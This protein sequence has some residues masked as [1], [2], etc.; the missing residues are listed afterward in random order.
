MT[1]DFIVARFWD[2]AQHWIQDIGCAH[3]AWGL[4]CDPQLPDLLRHPNRLPFCV[5]NAPVACRY[6]A[7]LAPLDWQ[8]FPERD[9]TT[10]W[11]IPTIPYAPFVA[12]Y[13]IK[14]DQQ[15]M[16][17]PGLRRY[18]VEHPVLTTILGFPPPVT[19]GMLTSDALDGCLPTHRHFARILRTMPNATLQWLLDDTVRLLQ[20]EL[21]SVTDDFGQA[22]SLDTKHILAWVKENNPKAYVKD[23]FDKDHQPAGDPDCK[24]G[25][26]RKHNQRTTGEKRTDSNEPP[27]PRRNPRSPKGIQI[28]EY[29]WGYA[30]GVIATKIF[31]WA[32]VVLAELTQTFDAADVSYFQ[33]L[34][35]DTERRLG[36]RPRFGAF[37]SAFDAWYV[38]EHF[39]HKGEPWQEAFAAVPWAKRGPKRTFDAKGLPLC[40]AGLPMPLKHAYMSRTD[41]VPH[42]KG[43]YACPLLYPEPTGADCPI[44]DPHWNKGGCTTTLATGIGARLRHQIDRE[45]TLY[46]EIYKQRTATERINSQA[47]ALG[48][49]R[50]KLRNRQAITNLNT[51]IYV[52]INLRALH[53]IRAKKANRAVV[54]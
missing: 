21:A 33:P 38:Y 31:G 45:S 22:I 25:C 2:A 47:K 54:A 11:C 28:G 23:R 17:M 34:M 37:D 5:R 32:E 7:L 30:S 40:K 18:L 36:F 10:D 39:H 50:P 53:R 27:T 51:L 46:K 4:L 43:R 14:L 13:L 24:L 29:Y 41:R 16:Y 3:Q 49:E 20:A 9:L 1:N 52:L 44:D 12:A 42:Q 8:H 26:K 15:L 48:I 35:V 19:H 6:L